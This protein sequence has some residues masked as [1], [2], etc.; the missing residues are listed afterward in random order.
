LSVCIPG[1][2]EGITKGTMEAM[3]MS[4]GGK[5]LSYEERLNAD[6]WILD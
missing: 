6:L 4:G 5:I 3:I 1:T 2:I